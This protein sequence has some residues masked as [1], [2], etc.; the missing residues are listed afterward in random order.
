MKSFWK[1]DLDSGRKLRRDV[2]QERLTKKSKN[3]DVSPRNCYDNDL[4]ER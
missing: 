4:Y 1:E 2:D 3:E